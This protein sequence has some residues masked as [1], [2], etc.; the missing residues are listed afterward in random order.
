MDEVRLVQH[1][2]RQRRALCV[3]D[4]L[5]DGVSLLEW[6]EVGVA[7]TLVLSVALTFVL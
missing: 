6:V 7:L 2:Q 5:L 3:L 4:G 1:T